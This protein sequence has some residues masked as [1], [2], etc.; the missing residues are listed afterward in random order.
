MSSQWGRVTGLLEQLHSRGLLSLLTIFIFYPWCHCSLN[1]V[2]F[3]FASLSRL[4]LIPW[5]RCQEQGSRKTQ[6]EMT[7][8]DKPPMSAAHTQFPGWLQSTC[9]S[10]PS[11]CTSPPHKFLVVHPQFQIHGVSKCCVNDQGQNVFS[12]TWVASFALSPIISPSASFG[13]GNGLG[14]NLEVSQEMRISKR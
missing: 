9:S 4:V 6:E 1:N 13:N 12:S 8:P 7:I 14:S 3:N 2:S 5:L 11:N 10:C